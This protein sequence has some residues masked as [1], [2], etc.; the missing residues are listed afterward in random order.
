MKHLILAYLFWCTG[1]LLGWHLA[2][3]GFN[4]QALSYA[5]T[6]GGWGWSWALDIWYLPQWVEAANAGTEFHERQMLTQKF[7]AMPRVSCWGWFM[8]LVLGRLVAWVGSS[9]LRPGLPDIAYQSVQALMAG[10]G[11][12]LGGLMCMSTEATASLKWT[13]VVGSSVQVVVEGVRRLLPELFAARD[14]K[15]GQAFT[16]RMCGLFASVAAFYLTRQWKIRPKK[17]QRRSSCSGLMRH[18]VLLL[19]WSSACGIGVWQ[20]GHIQ[21][22]NG[23]TGKMEDYTVREVVNNI[24]QSPIW[25]ELQ[26]S[27]EYLYRTYQE[28]GFGSFWEHLRVELD[29]DGTHRALKDLGVAT[30]ATRSEVKTAYRKLMLQYHPDK[31]SPEQ[32]ADPQQ[33]EEASDNFMRI[34]K[35]YETLQE[36]YKHD[37][38]EEL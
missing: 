19:L 32:L 17:T 13:I 20:H 8:Q 38:R 5:M 4:A 12:Y 2:Y 29:P 9:I 28:D 18:V 24:L 22:P 35:A 25:N 14:L 34:Q 37:P 1:G 30:T 36:L 11:V 15:V 26:S 3:L 23:Q 21:L 31:L 7:H 16:S 27:G 33:V 10:I 6:W